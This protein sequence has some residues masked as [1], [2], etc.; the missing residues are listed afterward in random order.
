MPATEGPIPSERADA[1]LRLPAD[2]AYVAVLRTTAAGL[3]ARLDFTL[4]DIEDL[5]MA[6]SEA[7]A[8]LWEAPAADPAATELTTR[9]WLGDRTLTLAVATPCSTPARVDPDSFSWQVLTAI[10][11][12]A[13]VIDATD[14][15]EIMVTTV[16]TPLVAPL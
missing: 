10:A 11:D 13:R 16:A 2:G 3:A 4:D 15:F 8:T 1:E 7:A 9:F 14:R 6:V 5:R 12:D